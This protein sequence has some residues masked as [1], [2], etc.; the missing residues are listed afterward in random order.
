MPKTP[1]LKALVVDD[2]VVYRK[3][4]SDVLSEIPDVEVVGTAH[5]GKAALDK[6]ASLKPDLM[7]LDIEMP[8]MNGLRVLEELQRQ[9]SD[10]G[11]IML[12]TLTL[13][14]GEMTMKALELGAFDFIPKPQ[15]GTMREN[16]KAVK[17]AIAPIIK[18]FMRSRSI[19]NILS[20]K[21]AYRTFDYQ[22]AKS[23]TIKPQ[24]QNRNPKSWRLVY[25]PAV[26][27]RYLKCSR[28]YPATS[29]FRF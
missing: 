3:I 4:V 20:G 26:Q 9:R 22:D 14:G 16:F 8:E 6:V 23:I 11:V 12:S 19:R 18:A 10:V 17:D 1:K 5:N 24:S 25:P 13:E 27:R 28:K 7:T 21:T 2:T 29:V 15:D